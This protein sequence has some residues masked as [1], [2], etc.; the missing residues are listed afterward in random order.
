M[1]R[2]PF[3]RRTI[4]L[5]P[6]D[7]YA[8][9]ASSYPPHPH[10]ALMVAEQSALLSMLDEVD[11]RTALDVGCG[12]GR[13][14]RELTARGAIA[15]GIDL[16]AAMLA[17]AQIVGRPVARADLRSLPVATASIDLIVC[18]LALGDVEDLAPAIAE[19]A[20]VLK[21]G[22]RLMYS[23]VHPA[24]RRLGWRRTFDAGDRQWAVND[25][26]HSEADHRDACA[27]ARLLIEDWLEPRIGSSKAALV[28]GARR[29]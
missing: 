16:S 14:L 21:S 26:W 6:Q 10:N 12:S 22:G 15:S 17:E 3:A 27:A 8:L 19:L 18:G 23:V 25:H 2:W 29:R 4:E 7:A 9:W 11:G 13:Y 5:A 24:G 28:V 1:R 20:R